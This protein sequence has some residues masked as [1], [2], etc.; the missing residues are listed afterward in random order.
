[1]CDDCD[2]EQFNKVA[3]AVSEGLTQQIT[4]RPSGPCKSFRRGD[5]AEKPSDSPGNR[6]GKTLL[7]RSCTMAA[8]KKAA[9]KKA[10]K[11]PAKKAAK[12]K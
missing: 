1:M 10:A 5:A 4:T 3:R 12:K 7:E 2:D 8:K 9:K 11:K 6:Q